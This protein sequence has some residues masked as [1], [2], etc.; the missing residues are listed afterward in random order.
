MEGGGDRGR[1]RQKEKIIGRKMGDMK[2]G[3]LNGKR[4]VYVR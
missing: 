1:E 2:A 4:E 3:E